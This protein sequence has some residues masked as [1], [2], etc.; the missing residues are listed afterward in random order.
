VEAAYVAMATPPA[1]PTSVADASPAPAAPAAAA[2][3]EAFGDDRPDS[4]PPA[5]DVSEKMDEFRS[6]VA[7]CKTKRELQDGMRP[8]QEFV[9]IHA[10][11]PINDVRFNKGGKLAAEMSNL[12]A[13]RKGEVPA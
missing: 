11:E 3:D 2:A 9:R 12:Y 10:S 7:G 1:D 8:W 13:T 6:W 5:D 4:A